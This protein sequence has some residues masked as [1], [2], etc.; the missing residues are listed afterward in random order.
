MEGEAM[1]QITLSL[2]AV[3][4]PPKWRQLRAELRQ[5]ARYGDEPKM[6]DDHPRLSDM[7]LKR[8]EADYV[9]DKR[10]PTEARA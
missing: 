3:G 10:L 5:R 8:I 6:L 4:R 9:G 1:S 2:D 7:G